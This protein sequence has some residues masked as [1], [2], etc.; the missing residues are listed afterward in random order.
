[1]LIFRAIIVSAGFTVFAV[2]GAAI[3]QLHNEPWA[4]PW[5][6]GPIVFVIGSVLG[7]IKPVSINSIFEHERWGR[8]RVPPDD[9]DDADT[10][11]KRIS[12]KS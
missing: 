10:T 11:E 4:E 9:S 7:I 12:E 8:L 5:V 3:S 1:M 2:I 6:V